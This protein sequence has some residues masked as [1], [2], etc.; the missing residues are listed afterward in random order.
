M[1][2]RQRVFEILS[3]QP[4]AP[5]TPEQIVTM[6]GSH[7]QP[8]EVVRPRALGLDTV[9]AA[10]KWLLA[11][12]P[13][14]AIKHRRRRDFGYTLADGATMPPDRRTIEGRRNGTD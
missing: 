12:E 11:H 14:L 1:N 2:N 13:P 3:R 9:R 4:G 8:G 7:G 10:L 6:S 5:L